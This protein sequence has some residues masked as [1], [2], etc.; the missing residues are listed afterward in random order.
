MECKYTKIDE[1]QSYFSDFHKDVYGTRPRWMSDEQWVDESWLEEQIARIH[2]YVDNLKLTEPGRN[3]LRQ[4]GFGTGDDV[5]D[6]GWRIEEDERHAEETAQMEENR[7][8][9]EFVA[10]QSAPLTTAEQIELEMY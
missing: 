10:E 7:K 4:L 9:C 1:L 3:H 5:A 2:L 8:M 6:L